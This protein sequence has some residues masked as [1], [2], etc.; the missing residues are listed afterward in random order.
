MM[1]FFNWFK[2]EWNTYGKKY[3]WENE[4]YYN[5]PYMFFTTCA[6]LFFVLV[7]GFISKGVI[8]LIIFVLIWLG[9]IL[10]NVMHLLLS[11]NKDKS[12]D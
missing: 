7:T 3:S 6:V 4:S 12:N 1:E 11:E 10:W 9:R 8:P 2:S 5:R